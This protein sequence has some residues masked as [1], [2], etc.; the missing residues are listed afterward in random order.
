[1]RKKL[2]FFLITIISYIAHAQEDMIRIVGS[3]AAYPYITSVAENFFRDHKDINIVVESTG[4]GIGFKLFCM[5]DQKKSPELIVSSRKIKT[6][7]KQICLKNKV[8]TI[9]ELEF[10]LDGI[11][12]LSSKSNELNNV[13][14]KNLFKALYKYQLQNN[15][16][17]TNHLQNWQ[18]IDTEYTNIPI[19]IYGPAASSATR[20]EFNHQVMQPGCVCNKEIFDLVKQDKFSCSEI[21]MDGIYAEIGKN[22]NLVI[23]KIKQNVNALGI[24]GY[25]FYIQNTDSVKAL[26]IDGVEPNVRTISNSQY[27]LS[28]KLYIYTKNYSSTKQKQNVKKFLLRLV[29]KFMIGYNGY[30]QSKGLIPLSDENI[31]LSKKK[32]HEKFP[33]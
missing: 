23:N 17:E 20:E 31:N 24:A 19:K 1:M 11:I 27:P 15:N 8:E 4:T 16:L 29:S 32:I 30:L 9:L 12:L 5:P 21:R 14:R 10:G 3:S 13:S 7:E 18:Q 25:N 2:L 33:S 22:E 6:S 26:K 28:R